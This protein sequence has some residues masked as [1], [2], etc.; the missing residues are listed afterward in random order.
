[1]ASLSTNLVPA[2][3]GLFG[4]RGMDSHALGRMLTPAGRA[5]RVQARVARLSN[6][7]VLIM[8][9]L[10][11][12]K[13]LAFSGLV[14]GRGMDSHSLARMLTPA[15]RAMRV[16]ARVARLSNLRGLIMASLSANKNARF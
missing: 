15:G 12:N 7:R 4:G 16:Q 5:V 1:M 11:A 10:S 13:V 8:A 3:S 2:F 6:L 9:S 14:G